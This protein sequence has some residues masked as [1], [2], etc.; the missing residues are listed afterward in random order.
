MDA[1]TKSAIESAIR[2]EKSSYDFYFIA[3]SRATDPEIQ[4]LFLKHASEEFEHLAGFIRL[5][6]GEKSELAPF[7]NALASENEVVYQELLADPHVIDS[8]EKALAVAINEER[9]C[10][11]QYSIFE[12]TIRIPEVHAMFRKALD[13]TEHHLANIEAEY[14]C[15]MGRSY[16]AATNAP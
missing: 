11:E 14:A 3:A 2:I 7:V 5:Y 15:C 1:Y 4:A 6:P 16:D 9:A 8:V 10:V 13:E 12:A